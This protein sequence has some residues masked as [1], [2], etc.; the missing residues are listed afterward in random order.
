MKN[1]SAYISEDELLKRFQADRN[2][3]WLGLILERYT[4][5]LLGVALKYLRDETAAKDIVQQVFLKALSEIPKGEIRNVGGWLYQ[6]ARNECL[7]YFRTAKHF[8]DEEILHVLQQP[9]EMSFAWLLLEEQKA[10][11]LSVALDQLKEEQKKCIQLFY[12]EQKSYH[13]IAELTGYTVKQV[14]SYIQNGKRN[15]KNILME[16]APHIFKSERH[17]K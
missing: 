12:L 11:E 1:K 17:E 3:E 10:K 16:S 4:A 14:K 7:N 8:V 13:Q 5:L 9:E 6:V 2:P 15:L